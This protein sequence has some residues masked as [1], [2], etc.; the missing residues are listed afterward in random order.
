[1]AAQS[2]LHSRRNFLAAS[3]ATA[4]A[5]GGAAQARTLLRPARPLSLP[6]ASEAAWRELARQLRG[7]VVRPWDPDFFKLAQPDNLRYANTLPQ[8]IARCMNADDVSAAI[9][10]AR[11][12]G[13]KLITR[14]GGHSYAGYSTTDGLMI[15]MTL[16]NA[17]TF[18]PASGIVTVAGGARNDRIYDKLDDA[19]VTI[20]HG[21]CPSV[22]AA[23]FLLGGGIGFNMRENGLACDQVMASDL[24]KADGTVV[25]LKKGDADTKDIFWAC[26]GGGGG[27]FG[28]STSFS[29][30]TIPVPAA[31]ITVFK[32]VWSRNT[33]AVTAEL[34]K[35]LESATNR[36]GSRVSLSAVTPDQQAHNRNVVV[37]L[38]GQLKGPKAELLAILADTYKAAAPDED[39]TDIQELPYWQGQKFLSEP[40]RPT[41][42]QE[43]SAF[44]NQALTPQAL[45]TGFAHLRRWPGT[46][47]YC[48]L[49]FFQ[50]GGAVNDVGPR[51]TAFIHRR[52]KWLMVVGLY[53]TCEDDRDPLRMARNH[54]WQNDF[55]R[56]MLPY[57]GGGAY[58]N[59]PDPSLADWRTSYYGDNLSDLTTIKRR[60]DPDR[61]FNFA[62]AL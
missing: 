15:D 22:G 55:Y 26:Q 62:Q 58:Q 57:A 36:L 23:A 44:V 7:P 61:V 20:T 40:A 53:W 46:R 56:A 5:L 47:D 12:T 51:D 17:V 38:L 8:G 48:D 13:I 18:D 1:M 28:I 42:Y 49:R 45:A 37:N 29:L 34:M 35:A 41:F 30:K 54:A 9:L 52:S 43:R 59:F 3:S 32:I 11:K 10:W 33:Q 31:P 60:L 6:L 4:L 19:N 25:S 50:T 39:E 14:S 16:M 2:Q 21:R 24:V 27:N